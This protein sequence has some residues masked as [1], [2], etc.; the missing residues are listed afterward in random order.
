MR[1]ILNDG[2]VDYSLDY[3]SKISGVC[4]IEWQHLLTR[5]HVTTKLSDV[6]IENTECKGTPK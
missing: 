3:A 4:S 5:K 1:W 6:F 2:Q